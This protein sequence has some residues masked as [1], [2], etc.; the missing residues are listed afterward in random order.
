VFGGPGWLAASADYDGD[1]KTDPAVYNSDTATWQ[2][3]QSGSLDATGQY[4]WWEGVAGSVGGLPAPADY[5]GDG[6]A[7]LAV[8]HLDT[9]IWQLFLSTSGYQE[10]SG[11][12]G[13]PA[14][15][16]AKE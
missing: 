15:Q 7:D 1:G 10:I 3:L 6:K 8:Y 11:G 2:V 12:F 9:G 5:D 4:T 13:G 16:P 14:Y